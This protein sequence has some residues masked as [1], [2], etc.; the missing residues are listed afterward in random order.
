MKTPVVWIEIPVSN[1]ERA[2]EFYENVF[3][4]KLEIRGMLKNQIALFDADRFGLKISLNIV[5]GYNGSNGVKPFFFVN[6][7]RDVTE[8]VVE[9]GGE[10]VMPPTI[11]KQMNKNGEFIIGKN[12]ID[13][14]VGYYAEVKDSEGNHLYLYSHS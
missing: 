4:T 7:I 10:V 14:E 13:N 9:H 5:N 1:F 6:I 3:E 8:R 12:L 11:L 2:V